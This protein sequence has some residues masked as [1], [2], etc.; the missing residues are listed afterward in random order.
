MI[1]LIYAM[2]ILVGEVLLTFGTLEAGLAI[3]GLTLVA[4]IVHSALTE[5]EARR[6]FL[7]AMTAV[8]LMRIL[9][10]ALPISSFPP[11]FAYAVVGIPLAVATLLAIRAIRLDVS[12][13]HQGGVLAQAL[14][15][16]LGIPLGILGSLLLVNVS[17]P[18]ALTVG[19]RVFFSLSL[20]LFTGFLEELIF[21]GLLQ[22]S[23]IDTFGRRGILYIALVSTVLVIG[24]RSPL[25]LLFV[26]GVS[27]FFGIVA[28]KSQSI[29]GV[30]VAHGL[31]SVL[32]LVILKGQI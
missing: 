13:L 18:G 21:R 4:L 30:S 2:V 14:I 26:F 12:C 23:A 16:L 7:V 1:A 25:N 19:E 6:R 22:Q 32:M 27:L 5:Y 17:F 8:P 29:L 9:S 3:Y 24:Y 11:I 20:L 15:G 31:M 28:Y 10:L